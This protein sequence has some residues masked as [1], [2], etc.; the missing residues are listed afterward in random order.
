MFAAGCELGDRQPEQQ[1]ARDRRSPAIARD[2]PPSH[3][4]P[5]RWHFGLVLCLLVAGCGTQRG[6]KR[7]GDRCA[8]ASECA[9]GYCVAGIHGDE[10]ACT[11][12]CGQ[13]DQ[14]PR[15]W[16]CSGVTEDNVL[17]CAFGAPTPFGIGARE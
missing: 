9:D 14:C 2:R 1:I 10:P 15:G 8:N 13:T 17:V 4:R 7:V 11:K 16:A 3:A 5:M 6:D 12:T